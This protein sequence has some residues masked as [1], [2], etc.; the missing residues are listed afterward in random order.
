MESRR[1]TARLGQSCHPA[2]TVTTAAFDSR[3][4][5]HQHKPT[6]ERREDTPQSRSGALGEDRSVV[7]CARSVHS[8]SFADTDISASVNQTVNRVH[9]HN[10]TPTRFACASLTNV[11]P[12]DFDVASG[13]WERRAAMSF[14]S[15]V[16]SSLSTASSVVH[17]CD[18]PPRAPD[19]HP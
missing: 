18:L 12:A 16:C 3:V 9:S 4:P 14:M 17:E 13:T 2:S 8:L 10:G 15:L 6:S 5:R 11:C 7:G 1:I 19:A